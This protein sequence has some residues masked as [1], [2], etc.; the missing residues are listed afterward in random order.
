MEKE[1]HHSFIPFN[2]V[3]FQQRSQLV[4]KINFTMMA[5]R[6]PW[7][8]VK[9][10]NQPQRGCVNIAR[11]GRTRMAATAVAVGNFLRTLTQGKL[12]P[13][14]PGFG[15]ESRWDS[16]MAC[17]KRNHRFNAKGGIRLRR[18]KSSDA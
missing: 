6:L 18:N 2:L 13:R 15:T 7:V 1:N 12:V 5:Q 14:N 9:N 10:W 11:D 17:E 8:N 3:S 4:L 16:W